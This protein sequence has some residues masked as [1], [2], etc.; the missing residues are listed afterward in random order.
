[1]KS[2]TTAALISALVFPGAGHIYLKKYV[3]GVILISIS[4]AA[5]YILISEATAQA[6]LI[7]EEMQNSGAPIDMVS[8]SELATRQQPT[9]SD[10][11]AMGTAMTIL[12]ICWIAG[13]IDS[14]RLGMQ[15]NKK[16]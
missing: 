2:T 5:L 14:I 7:V 10:T 6:F 8:I 15:Q 1:M 13:I 3:T 11:G 16:P 4:L 12:I 9:G